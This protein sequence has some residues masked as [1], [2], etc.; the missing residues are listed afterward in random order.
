MLSIFFVIYASNK[1]IQEIVRIP[2]KEGWDS[3]IPEFNAL[4]NGNY[5][6]IQLIVKSKGDQLKKSTNYRGGLKGGS[7]S[8]DGILLRPCLVRKTRIE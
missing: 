7:S 4:C 2:N 6:Y 8:L 3:I 5:E 1:L